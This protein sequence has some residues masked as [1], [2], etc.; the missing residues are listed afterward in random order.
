[1]QISKNQL[2]AGYPAIQVRD[3]LREF[4][5]SII[6]IDAIQQ[7]LHVD[8]N[9]AKAFLRSMIKLGYLESWESRPGGDKGTY[10]VATPGLALANASAAKPITR[11][12][13]ER[14]LRE[15]MDRV[16]AI[17]TGTK[18]P[19]AYRITSAVLFGSMLSDKERLGDVDIAIE[20]QPTTSNNKELNVLCS[21]RLR[22]AHLNGKRFSSDFDQI[23]WPMTE[24]YHV[25]KAHSRRLSLHQLSELSEMQNVSCRVLYGDP[26]RLRSMLSGGIPK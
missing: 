12:T 18:Y 23:V 16:Q 21:H 15:F 25:L 9:E 22:M 13:A 19:Y 7:A 6:R 26:V 8:D 5:V 24:I 17:T 1:M 4:R 3:F 10:E 14:L 2:I 20:V 11:K